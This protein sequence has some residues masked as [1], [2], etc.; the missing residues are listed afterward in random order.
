MQ[1]DNFEDLFIEMGRIRGVEV[2]LAHSYEH[3]MMR[4]PIHLSIGQ[5]Y[6]L[7]LIYSQYQHG[8]RFYSSHRSHGLCLALKG[9]LR[10]LSAEIHGT[11]DGCLSGIGGKE[12]FLC[13]RH[14]IQ[15]R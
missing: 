1:I 9:G 5:E 6:W 10:K 11:S 3:Q 8:D 15:H 14:L 13:N 7:P 12:F 4:C 2:A